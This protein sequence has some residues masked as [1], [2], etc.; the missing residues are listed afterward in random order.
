MSK[1]VSL[2]KDEK[3]ELLTKGMEFKSKAE[4]GRLADQIEK[5]VADRLQLI[6]D[7]LKVGQKVRFAGLEL[8]L[9]HVE[10]HDKKVPKTG[11][12]KKIP[13]E[14]VIKVKKVKAKKSE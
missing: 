2:K 10:A 13:A 7:G 12:I 5:E 1:A 6:Y 11:E 8:E 3:V 4:Q 14:D 9:R